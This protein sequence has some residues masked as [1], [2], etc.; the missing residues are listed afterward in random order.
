MIHLELNNQL[1][2]EYV[3]KSTYS[4]FIK[5]ERLFKLEDCFLKFL[6]KHLEPLNAKAQQIAFAAFKSE[7]TLLLQDPYEKRALEYFD[8][9][10]WLDSKIEKK[11]FAEIVSRN[12][13][14]LKE[15]G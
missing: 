13:N 6:K 3:Y 5:R 12:A 10:S 1:Q 8:F 7:L 14:A 2:L 11:S 9:I 4:Y 15:K